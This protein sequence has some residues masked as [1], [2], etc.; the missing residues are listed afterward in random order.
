M[1]TYTAL[2][3]PTQYVEANGV[4]FAYRRLGPTGGRTGSI[5]AALHGHD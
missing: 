1:T 2:T 3:A 4:R 5:P